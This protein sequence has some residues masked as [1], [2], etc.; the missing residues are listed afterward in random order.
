MLSRQRVPRGGQ[1][2]RSRI[3]YIIRS[4]LVYLVRYVIC[5]RYVQYYVHIKT[6]EWIFEACGYLGTQW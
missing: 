3:S 4:G 2:D 6:R 5:H 1:R